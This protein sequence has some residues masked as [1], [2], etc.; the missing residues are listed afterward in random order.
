MD[1]IDETVVGREELGGNN[2]IH[3]TIQNK[4]LIGN[5]CVAQENLL[6]GL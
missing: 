3:T 6:H 5:Y 1:T 4:W 2:I